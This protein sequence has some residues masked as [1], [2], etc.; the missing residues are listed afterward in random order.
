MPNSSPA[1][2]SSG[3]RGEAAC[4]TGQTIV[5]DGGRT[6]E[7]PGDLEQAAEDTG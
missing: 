5:S 4:V 1:A 2:S 7:I 3:R 6:L